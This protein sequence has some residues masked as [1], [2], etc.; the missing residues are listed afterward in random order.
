MISGYVS[1]A[2]AL[3]DLSYAEKAMKAAE[4]IQVFFVKSPACIRAGWIVSISLGSLDD[5]G[6][7]AVAKCLCG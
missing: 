4:F 5:F 3:N 2:I 1:A 6:Q 7:K